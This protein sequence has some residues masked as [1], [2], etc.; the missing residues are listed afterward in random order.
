MDLYSIYG[1][2]DGNIYRVDNYNSAVGTKNLKFDEMFNSMID[3]DLENIFQD[4]SSEYGVDVNL[5]KAVAQAESGMDPNATSWCG[6]MGIM[7]L[8]PATAQSYGVTNPYDARQSITGGAK[9]LSWL[10]DDYNGNV[11]LALAGY[12]AGCGSVQKYGGVPPYDETINYIHKINDLLGGALEADSWTIDGSTKTNLSNADMGMVSYSAYPAAHSTKMESKS[13]DLP[14]GNK[15]L[16]RRTLDN[17]S[18]SIHKELNVDG[19]D[20]L[21]NPNI[22]LINAALSNA[23]EQSENT[24]RSN[25]PYYLYEQQASIVNSLISK[26]KEL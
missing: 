17:S 8:M 20:I 23:V 26:I 25:T 1:I 11:S 16:I 9:L 7:Q 10:L 5:L 21:K 24:M 14:D 12:N 13:A 18:K 2:L 22:N 3:D 4:V 15:Y 6:A 19:E